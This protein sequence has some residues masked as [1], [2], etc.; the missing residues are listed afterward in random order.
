[1]ASGVSF[2]RAT[3]RNFKKAADKI[4]KAT[5]NLKESV[6]PALR[7]IGDEIM[8]D[9]K[10]SRAGHGVPVETGVLRGT[11]IVTGPS[12]GANPEVALTFGGPAAP[13][14]LVQ[15]EVTWFYHKVG[16][17]RYLVRGLERWKPGSSAAYNEYRKKASEHLNQGKK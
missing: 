10:S 1:M 16:E 17:S 9:V 13:Y 12:G 4:R 2:N 5:S 11:G 3:V 14:A 8:T 15:H 7:S 6:G